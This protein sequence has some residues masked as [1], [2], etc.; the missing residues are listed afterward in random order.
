MALQLHT[1]M[2]NS[3]DFQMALFDS[4][5]DHMSPDMDRTASEKKFI[6][7]L[8]TRGQRIASDRAQTVLK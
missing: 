1:I 8:T 5:K 6:S 2:Q 7:F 4:V 3:G